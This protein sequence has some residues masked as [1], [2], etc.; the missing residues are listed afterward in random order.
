MTRYRGSNATPELDG[1]TLVYIFQYNSEPQH[2]TVETWDPSSTYIE[3][4]RDIPRIC[5]AIWLNEQSQK[6]SMAQNQSGHLMTNDPNG[7][8]LF[9]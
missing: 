7:V 1:Q 8:L 2:E 5:H 9:D 3:Y 6:Y 4:D